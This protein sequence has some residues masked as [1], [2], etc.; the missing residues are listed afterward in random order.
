M[1]HLA[2]LSFNF[3]LK[4]SQGQNAKLFNVFQP[5]TLHLSFCSKKRKLQGTI[6]S[7]FMVFPLLVTSTM[8]NMNIATLVRNNL[9]VS[10]VHSSKKDSE[11]QWLTI[12]IN[13]DISII[14]I[15]K[16]M[17]LYQHPLIYSRDFN[18]HHTF[19]GYSP[20]NP[21]GEALHDWTYTVE[22]KLLFDHKQP[23]A[24]HSAVWN[25]HTIQT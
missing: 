21:D 12:I 8:Y 11:M 6:K 22:L 9:T 14:N 10:L 19:W 2:Q 24:F 7:T 25:I 5:N 15:Y 3:M 17:L 20:N 4:A 16:P 23:K 18:Y 13:D 1:N